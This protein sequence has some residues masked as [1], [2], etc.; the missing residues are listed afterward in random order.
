[1]AVVLLVLIGLYWTGGYMRVSPHA[2]L[3]LPGVVLVA[4]LA[5]QLTLPAG[6]TLKEA[7][8]GSAANWFLLIGVA[9]VVLVYR[10]GLMLLKARHDNS[11]APAPAKK[12]AFSD[13]ELDRYARHIILREVG[14]PGQKKLKAAKVLVVGAGG[15]GAPA[16]QYLAAMG[17]GTIGI[18]D[19]D[20]VSVSNLQ[21]QVIHSD[22]DVGRPKVQSAADAIA[23]QNPFVTVKPYNRRLEA[24]IANDLV[25]DYDL[26]LDG[27]DNF[28]T[29]Y[30][31][32]AACVAGKVPLISA[33]IT[34]WEG[35]ISLFDP[36]T[37]GPCYACVFPKAPARELVPTCAEAGVIGALP[38]VL[39]AMMAA[40]ATKHITGAGQT[41]KN[42][43]TIYD[44][45][46]AETRTIKVSRRADCEICGSGG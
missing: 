27:S 9:A 33:A 37:D 8:G 17:V 3:L 45:L 20:V 31:V 21:R 30:L 23:A 4:V 16:L 26:V 42:R 39:G 46:Y 2:R 38:G 35:Q 25:A 28:E 40:E 5:I 34:Q 18:I 24:D 14:G 15:L 13:A 41:L 44:A 6:N 22:S 10:Q 43:L 36:A 7:T 19:D 11:E 1:M 12:G 29:R 32:N